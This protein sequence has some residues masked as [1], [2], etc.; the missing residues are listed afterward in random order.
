MVL[1]TDDTLE[2]IENTENNLRDN[3][4]TRFESKPNYLSKVF[5]VVSVRET[6]LSNGLK[7]GGFRSSQCDQSAAKNVESYSSGKSK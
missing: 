2:V 5:L 6:S 1:R 4:G 7:V 3:L